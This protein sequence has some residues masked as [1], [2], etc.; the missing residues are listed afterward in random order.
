MSPCL[1][2]NYAIGQAGADD[3]INVAAGTYAEDVVVTK[4]L[5]FKGANAGISAG[6]SPGV[7]GAESVVKTFR[8]STGASVA[9][10]FGTTDM[11]VTI[12]GFTVDPQGDAALEGSSVLAGLIHLH[13]GSVTGTSVV[14]NIVRGAASF[15]PACTAF[16][17]VAPD[18]MA[19]M[20]ISVG[21]GAMDISDN[22]VEN[23]RYGVR[24]IQQNGG[25]FSP[26]VETVDSNV[27]TGVTVQ[28]I[29]IGG[30]TGVQAPGG[31]ITNNEIDAVGR[32]S[33]PGG[34][35]MTNSG[36]VV[37]GNTFTDMGAG[38]SLVLCKKWD[39]R[40]NTVDDNTFDGAP[41]TVSVSTDGGQCATG[42]GGDTEGV[43]S[44][45]TNGGRFDGFNANG[46]SFTGGAFA[47][48]VDAFA[49]FSANKPVTPGPIDVTCNFWNDAS[50]PTNPANPTGTGMVL[51]FSTVAGQPALR[52]HAVGD[53]RRRSLHRRPPA[54]ADGRHRRRRGSAA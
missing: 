11:D 41:L 18:Q 46:N 44:W 38:V 27:I 8:S 14:N 48:F 35:V 5:V 21:S 13:G 36:N 25:S 9:A 16:S 3:I 15:F 40:N 12:D 23:L 54:R 29:G 30:A 45:V 50:G 24:T 43:G 10:L 47:M 28:G 49:G 19:P 39:A 42:S 53:L 51:A 34:V 33:S 6:T 32:A 4:S 37:S 26:L 1:T 20:G 31:D 2:I 7:R 17:C 52:L 22:R